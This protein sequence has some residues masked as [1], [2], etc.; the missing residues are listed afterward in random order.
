[1]KNTISAIQ[2]VITAALR[3]EIPSDWLMSRRVPVHTLAALK[4]GALRQHNGTYTGILVVITGAGLKVSEETACWIRDHLNPLFVINIGTCGLTNR[5]YSLGKWMRPQ[6]VSNENGKQLELD[7]RLPL[8]FHKKIINVHSLI[9]V[10]KEHLNKLPD[11]WKEHNV[12]DMECYAQANIFG[13]TGI[14]FHCLKF[15]ADYSDNNTLSDFNMNLKL[16]QQEI[17]NLFQFLDEDFSK[18]TAVVPVYNR[19]NIVKRA[20]D[21]VLNQSYKPEEI[22]VVDD[23]S[24]DGTKDALMSYGEKISLI[25]LPHNSGPSAARNAGIGHARTEWIAFMDSDDCWEKDKLR[26]QVGYLAKY[27][28][29]QI[30]QSD[31]I[32]IRNGKRVNPCKHH[33][34]PAGWIWEPSLERCLVSPSGVLV[35]KGL[36]EKYG[37]FDETLP[38]CEDYDLWLK[39]SRHHPVGLEPRFSVIKYGGHRDQLSRKYSAMDRFR[40]ESLYKLLRTEPLPRFRRK[41]INV[42]NKKL[43]ILIKGYEKRNKLKD[44]E[45]CGAMLKSLGNYL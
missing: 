33:K 17:K 9:S 2:L 29:Y 5:R 45:A 8:P 42:L 4:S 44:A 6:C 31:E 19:E 16:L 22:I 21:S 40:I 10:K 20:V 39:I 37:K 25:S 15:G 43:N 34:K 7:T 23:C 36:L 3:K 11:L 41:I 14:S 24:T 32:W 26:E 28:F 1:M 30:M 35:K 12:I 13:K 18:V 27:P 38:V